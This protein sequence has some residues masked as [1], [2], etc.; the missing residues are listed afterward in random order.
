MTDVLEYMIPSPAWALENHLA[1]AK[2]G[3]PVYGALVGRM[4]WYMKSASGFP[5][6]GNTFD[7]NYVYQSITENGWTSPN[8]FKMFASKSWPGA[9]GGIAWAPRFFTEATWNAPLITADSTYR[10]YSDCGKFTTANLGGPIATQ[11]SGPVYKDFGGDLGEQDAIIVTYLWGTSMEV[12]YYVKDYGWVQWE[13][14][15]LVNGAYVQKQVSAFNTFAKGGSP[16]LN[17][18]CPVPTI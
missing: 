13:L 17:F 7:E 9:N 5:W 1:V 14:W 16:T 18:P 8:Q 15:S 10:T 3:Q 4:L 12:N 6:D 11:L 2:G